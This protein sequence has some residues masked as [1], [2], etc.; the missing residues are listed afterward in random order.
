[1]SC[2][3][4]C[5]ATK[6]YFN[7]MH[8]MTYTAKNRLLWTSKGRIETAEKASL[9]YS[10]VSFSISVSPTTM[11]MQLIV[12]TTI[13]WQPMRF[14]DSEPLLHC[15]PCV[16]F[17][18]YFPLKTKRAQQGELFLLAIFVSMVLSKINQR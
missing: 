2:T 16:I 12:T 13:C 10:N 14:R 8:G 17:R 7:K 1:M 4:R 6:E 5:V 15:R 9:W 11:A 3:N 18:C